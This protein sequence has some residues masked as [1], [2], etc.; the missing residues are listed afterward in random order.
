MK[1]SELME[2]AY[3]FRLYKMPSEKE[4]RK[5]AKWSDRNFADLKQGYEALW[6]LRSSLYI[7]SN[8]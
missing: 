2:A 6:R 1:L 8:V 7:M 4:I 3:G 5:E